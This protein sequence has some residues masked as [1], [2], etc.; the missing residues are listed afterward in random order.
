MTDFDGTFP[1]ITE[2]NGVT[3]TV[4]KDKSIVLNGTPTIF[5][6]I[7]LGNADLSER[8]EYYLSGAPKDGYE[9]TC[10]LHIR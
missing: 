5:T 8:Q 2:I 1:Y 6:R 10:A 3:V 9:Y 7:N 4:N